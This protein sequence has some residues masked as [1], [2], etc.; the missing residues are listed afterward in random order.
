MIL[1]KKIAWTALFFTGFLTMMG[2]GVFSIAIAIYL[3]SAWSIIPCALIIIYFA[4]GIPL[5]DMVVDK[6]WGLDR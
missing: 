6:L 4:I 1:L 3:N 2:L 5:L